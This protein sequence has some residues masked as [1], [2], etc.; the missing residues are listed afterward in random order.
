[1]NH[2]IEVFKRDFK[3]FSLWV[4]GPAP[5]FDMTPHP[6]FLLINSSQIKDFVLPIKIE[7]K[8]QDPDDILNNI[9]VK[10]N[11]QF[12]TPSE[13][14]LAVSYIKFFRQPNS[15]TFEGSLVIKEKQLKD[16]ANKI[17]SCKKQGSKKGFDIT[18]VI[19]ENFLFFSEVV[20]KITMWAINKNKFYRY[21][22]SMMLYLSSP[23]LI[24]I[25][26]RLATVNDTI[27]LF[28]ET[29]SRMQSVDIIMVVK[30]GDQEVKPEK[31]DFD[32]NHII[33]LVKVPTCTE[34][35]VAVSIEHVDGTV[36]LLIK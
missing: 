19:D 31:I 9:E 27:K 1:M 15:S 23:K 35:K 7:A 3:N 30:F 13:E 28:L 25:Y 36:D 24:G 29:G 16:L 26:P 4:E 20:G 34:S 22:R 33:V 6:P 32:F 10:V 11:I 12:Y 17:N 21:K 2:L 14:R 5:Y 8:N 18:F